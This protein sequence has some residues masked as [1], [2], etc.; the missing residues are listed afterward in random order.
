MNNISKIIIAVTFPIVLFAAMHV[1]T[2][3]VAGIILFHTM[4][5]LF[6]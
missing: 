5:I 1:I 2:M 3:A 4:D 6:S